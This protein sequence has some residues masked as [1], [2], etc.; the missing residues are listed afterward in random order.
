MVIR[1]AYKYS[2]QHEDAKHWFIV[3]LV[4]FYVWGGTLA[5]WKAT[6]EGLLHSKAPSE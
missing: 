1:L 6:A 5:S 3:L 4:C 2:L